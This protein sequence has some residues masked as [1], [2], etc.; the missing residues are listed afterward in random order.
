MLREELLHKAE[1]AGRLKVRC[2]ALVIFL[3]LIGGRF[4]SMRLI[5]ICIYVRKNI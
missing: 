5:F 4:C 2:L 1:E 3:R